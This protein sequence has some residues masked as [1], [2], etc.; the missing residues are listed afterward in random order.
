[1]EAGTVSWVNVVETIF[2]KQRSKWLHCLEKELLEDSNNIY[3][4]LLEIEEAELVGD[5]IALY[6]EFEDWIELD[7]VDE[8]EIVSLCD[9]DTPDS[10]TVRPDSWQVSYNNDWAAETPPPPVSA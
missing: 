4:K 9:E 8:I 5:K 1:M 7:D 3:K 6:A 10:T 2:K